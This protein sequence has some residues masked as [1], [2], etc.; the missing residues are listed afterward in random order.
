MLTHS[1]LS[2]SQHRPERR[3]S[4]TTASVSPLP[5]I[6]VADGAPYFVTENG[7]PWT[8]IG[9]NDAITWPELSGLFRR[10]NLPAVEA[11]LR[12][13]VEHG[14]TCLRLMLEYAHRAYRYLER[15]VGVFQ[16]S[17]VRLWDDLFAL[18]ERVG[19]RILLTPFDTFFTWKRWAKHPYNRANGGPCAARTHL[20]VCP[21]TREAV[22]QRLA[23]ATERWGGSGALFAWD[24]WNELHP[25]QGDNRIDGFPQLIDD[26]GGSLRDLEIRLYGRAHPQTVSVFGPELVSQPALR[27]P[28]FRHPTLDF[29]NSHFYEHGTI[30]DPRNTVDPAVSAGRLVREALGE[31]RDARPFFDSEHGPIHV[32]KDRHQTLPEPFDNEYFRHMQ[33]AHFASG[34][35]GGGMRWPNRSPHVLTPGMRVAQH[36]LAAFLPLIHWPR[37]RRR[38][39]NGQLGISASGIAGFACGDTEQAVVWLL[40]TDSLGPDG[41]LRRGSGGVLASIRVPGLC[42]GRYR[43]T[44]WDTVTGASPGAH[45]LEHDGT[46]ALSITPPPI[47]TDLALAVRRLGDT[48][49]SGTA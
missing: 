37:F 7:V 9:Q 31:I 42:P 47:T 28:I 2:T 39:L 18:C 13:L 45:E 16:R 35:A 32:F 17:M 49:V 43:V 15:P 33:W 29:A 4:P 10:R 1:V 8:P 20:L 14:V 6:Q 26:L 27:E 34:G 41:M 30:D 22:K 21:E 5:W 19:L 48:G 40:R 12:K 24:L 46:G 3:V 36:A 44:V 38:N 23:F 11:H 25:A